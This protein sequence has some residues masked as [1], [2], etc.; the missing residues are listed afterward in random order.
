MSQGAD[1]GGGEV[2]GSLDRGVIRPAT[3]G[4]IDSSSSAAAPVALSGWI[5]GSL[6]MLISS[7]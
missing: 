7:V 2:E 1:H 5:K 3:A 4:V 6:V